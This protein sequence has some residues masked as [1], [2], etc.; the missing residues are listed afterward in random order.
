MGRQRWKSVNTNL[1]FPLNL[2]RLGGGWYR[3]A[4]AV[5]MSPE[6]AFQTISFESDDFSEEDTVCES[7]RP[8]T[9]TP[10]M[11]YGGDRPSVIM[12]PFCKVKLTSKSTK[13]DQLQFR[14]CGQTYTQK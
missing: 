1:P 6:I 12:E 7:P 13:I 14:Y 3:A 4:D 11:G 8:I 9:H 2:F 10:A 5:G